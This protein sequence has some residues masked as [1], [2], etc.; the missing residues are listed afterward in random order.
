MLFGNCMQACIKEVMRLYPAIPVFP[1]EAAADDLLPSQHPV[2]KGGQGSG[3]YNMLHVI[4]DVKNV[5]GALV[6]YV[7]WRA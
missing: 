3:T 2:S 5:K 7:Y 1:R 6:S 4:L